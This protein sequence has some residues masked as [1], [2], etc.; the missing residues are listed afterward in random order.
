MAKTQGSVKI[1][2]KLAKKEFKREINE[3]KKETKKDGEEIQESLEGT[4]FSSDGYASSLGKVAVIVA[5]IALVVGVI[6]K[7][8]KTM[9]KDNEQLSS[10]I[11]YIKFVASTMINN[12][13]I[14]IGNKFKP[15]IE[16]IINLVYQLLTYINYIA[17]AWFGIDLMAGATTEAFQNQKKALAGSNKEAKQLEKTLLGFDKINKLDSK[18]SSSGGAGAGVSGF[19]MPDIQIPEGEIPEWLQWIVDSK[20]EILALLA[21]LVVGLNALNLGFSG[22]ES[23]GLGVL[24]AG[25]LLSIEGIVDFINDPSWENFLTIVE[26]I[27]LAIAGLAIFCEAWQIALGALVAVVVAY[28]VKNW[29]KIK[30]VL[31]KAES[32]INE[33]LDWLE[34]KFGI[35]GTF[36]KGVWQSI[37]DYAVDNFTGMVKPIKNVVEGIIKIFKGDLK[38]GIMDVLKGIGNYFISVLN[39]IIDGFNLFTAPLRSLI[40]A[41]GK[42]LGKGWTIDNVKIPRVNYLAQ[43]GIIVNRPGRGV[44]VGASAYAGEYQREGVLPLTNEASMSQLGLEIGKHVK[45]NADITLEIERRVLARVMK[46]IQN[47]SQFVGG[48]Y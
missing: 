44:P 10:N 39:K 11:E 25:I 42:I 28:V 36:I 40:V 43:G 16:S 2:V 45:V 26:G 22:I 3:L 27:G 17:K 8:I 4:G 12:L 18:D 29:D 46:E 1:A 20:D 5:Q 14:A 37:R 7:S 13:L 35:V 6:S 24:F 9:I 30:G 34:E 38:G 19:T 15:L 33:K 21:G 23:L 32:W 47:D 41:V 31:E 48:G